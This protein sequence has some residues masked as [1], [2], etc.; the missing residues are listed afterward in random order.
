MKRLLLLLLI[1]TIAYAI[2]EDHNEYDDVSLEIPGSGLVKTIGK[3]IGKGAGKEAGKKAGKETGKKAGKETGKKAGKE[4]GKVK[5]PS[6]KN[7][8]NNKKLPSRKNPFS[9]IDGIKKGM[10]KFINQKGKDVKKF[11]DQKGKDVKKFI[12]QK[13]K[14]AKKFIDQ[15]GKDVKR[16]FDRNINPTIKKVK[17]NFKNKIERPIINKAKQ[18]EKKVV[19]PLEKKI[20]HPIFQRI[21]KFLN[22]HPKIKKISDPL[23]KELKKI[24]PKKSLKEIL[25]DPQNAGKIIHK[26]FKP[27]IDKV[28]D[29]HPFKIIKGKFKEFENF[30]EKHN[31][32]VKKL[33]S[34]FKDIPKNAQKA[35]N[36]LTQKGRN[37]IYWLKKKGYWEPI[38]FVVET[39]GQYAAES[40]CSLYLTP[41]VCGPVVD[42]AFTFGVNRYLDSL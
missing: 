20:A 33:T 42:V 4:T 32:P 41:L 39:G 35:F 17:Q 36:Q 23:I 27:F 24:D 25:K 12:D 1:S 21:N 5:L 16:I 29:I 28:K 11:I 37:A 18:I 6:K 15:K 30:L 2:I 22:D 31:I 40:L 7:S 3:A 9:T 13:G 10:E 19:V 34:L 14:D 8:S 38:K 26:T